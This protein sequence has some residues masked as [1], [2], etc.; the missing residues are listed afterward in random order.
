MNITLET[1]FDD[2]LKNPC[3]LK[4]YLYI[5]LKFEQ[6]N[7][8]VI[9]IGY[10][11]LTS[12]TGLSSSTIQ[13]AIDKLHTSG[14]IDKLGAT[15]FGISTEKSESGKSK[16]NLKETFSIRYSNPAECHATLKILLQTYSLEEI[17]KELS[18]ANVQDWLIRQ[19]WFN[20][21][22]ALRN[23]GKIR[24]GQYRK[25]KEEEKEISFTN[26]KAL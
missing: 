22:W 21:D 13:K 16:I 9:Q 4:L 18:G 3:V 12:A 15:T 25:Y 26:Y 11:E 14:L 24:C 23:F 6:S 2:R 7:L 1:Y 10:K 5:M 20:L 8:S 17:R 19:A